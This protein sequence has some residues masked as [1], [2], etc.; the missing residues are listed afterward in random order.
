MKKRVVPPWR[1]AGNQQVKQTD[2]AGERA[3]A[4]YT[5]MR[6]AKLNGL[7][8]ETY[9]RDVLSKISRGPHRQ[10]DQCAIALEYRPPKPGLRE[11]R[12]PTDNQRRRNS[13]IGYLTPEQMAATHKVADMAAQ[14]CP[15][16]RGKAT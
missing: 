9:L 13:A 1:A 10:Q 4:I 16:N 14:P 11:A 15:P 6:T 12:T 2:S 5:I 7:N 8:P 3:A